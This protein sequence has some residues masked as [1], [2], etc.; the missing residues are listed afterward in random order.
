MNKEELLKKRG[1]TVPEGTIAVSQKGIGYFDHP[2]FDQSIEIQP[3]NMHSALHGDTVKIKIL[4]EPRWNKK[5]GEILEVTHRAKIAFVGVL[6]K[7][8]E[9]FTL[10]PDDKRCY[11]PIIVTPQ[12][13]GSAKASE[14]VFVKITKWTDKNAEGAVAEVIGMP[15]LHETEMR[16]IVLDRGFAYDYPAAVVR[17]AEEIEKHKEITPEERANRRDFTKT[18][19]VTIDPADAKD[20]DDAISFKKIGDDKYEIGIHIADVSHYVKEGTALDAEARERGFSVYLVDR[21][22]P[23]LP[24]VLSN[25]VCSLNPHEEK[26]VFSAVFEMNGQGKISSRWFGKGIIKSAKRFTYEN[27]QET[28]DKGG[29]FFD[30]LN[31][32][33]KIAKI[34]QKEKFANGAMD[35]EQDEIKFEL[36]KNGVPIRIFKKSRKDTHKLVEEYMLLANRE[37]GEYM[38]KKMEKKQGVFLYRIHDVPNSERIANLA[39]FAKAL[40]YDLP[41]TKNGVTVKDLQRLMKQIEGKPQESLIKTAAVRSM[42]KAVY[43]PNNIGHY[44]LAYEY[45]THFTSPIRRYADLIVHRLLY[46]E[47]T[48]GKISSGEYAKYEKIG[49]ETTEKEIRAAD[50]ERT[51]IRY[52]Q[53]EFMQ[54]KRGQI[55]EGTISGVMGFGIFVAEKDTMTEGMVHITKLPGPDFYTFD[56]KNYSLVGEKSKRRFTLGDKVKFKIV[57]ADLEKRTLDYELVG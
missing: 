44:G 11:L 52:K 53:I 13:A 56:E 15:G 3:E 17:E 19:T 50:A 22:I 38:Y 10:V 8:G 4:P 41:I 14:K 46:R 39:I 16:A 9:N 32:L 31:T 2:D 51:S 49:M 36:D 1:G 33:N 48:G 40:G 45:Y 57:G 23:M 29:E 43:S 55:F 25:D 6:K 30:E 34:F 35:F 20:F 54:N 26:L 42:A 21:T 5:Q 28:L 7:D 18:L 24:E 37:V 27:A 12:S 47:L